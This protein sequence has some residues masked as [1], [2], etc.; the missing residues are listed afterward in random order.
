LKHGKMGN[1]LRTRRE[2]NRSVPLLKEWKHEQ[3]HPKRGEGNRASILKKRNISS[4]LYMRRVI[5]DHL[6]LNLFHEDW[7][8]K[9]HPTRKEG[10]RINLYLK[11]KETGATAFKM[12]I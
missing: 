8:K 4:T 11:K 6:L 10:I 12:A 9:L 1:A 7:K 5:E 3:Q 2:A